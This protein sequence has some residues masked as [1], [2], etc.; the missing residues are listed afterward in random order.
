MKEIKSYADF[1]FES[2]RHKRWDKGCHLDLMTNYTIDIQVVDHAILCN[3]QIIAR[4]KC[5]W[6]TRKAVLFHERV[7]LELYGKKVGLIS[8]FNELQNQI[9]TNP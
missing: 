7:K 2:F 8:R 5:N 9:N 1:L 4:L 3:D 6:S